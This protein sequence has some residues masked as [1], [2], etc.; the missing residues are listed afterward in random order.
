MDRRR[1]GWS[2]ILLALVLSAGGCTSTALKQENAGLRQKVAQDEAALKARADRLA[3]A[4]AALARSRTQERRDQA[5]IAR[6][7]RE[8]RK[9]LE[10][11][12]ALVR[13]IKSLTIVEMP[14]DVLFGVGQADL[15]QE[16]ITIVEKIAGVFA[17]FPG[18]HMRI[19]GHTDN[20][21]IGPRLKP[22]YDSNW[23]L[24]AAR[25]ATVAK[26]LI[27]HLDVPAR[28]LYIAAYA[29]TRP[30][31]DNAR[32]EGRARNRRLRIVL[33]QNESRAQ[34]KLR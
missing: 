12:Q 30:I 6:L 26:Y 23:E 17:R 7:R 28:R 13:K 1:Q 15:S 21:P 33:I 24:S 16:G 34:M 29:D 9:A 10:T 11:N 27:Y 19:E 22:R 2:A 18:I 3:A 5:E 20:R 31:A 32:P 4:E 8:L 14:Y 25:A